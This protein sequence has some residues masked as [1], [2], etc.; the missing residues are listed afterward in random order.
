VGGMRAVL[1]QWAGGGLPLPQAKAPSTVARL[2][3][4]FG[5]EPCQWGSGYFA[6]R[7]GSRKLAVA[8]QGVHTTSKNPPPISGMQAYISYLAGSIFSEVNFAL[9]GSFQ[10]EVAELVVP[11]RG[12]D[13]SSF[14]PGDDWPTK[15]MVR[16]GLRASV[17]STTS[18]NCTEF[19]C[20]RTRQSSALSFLP[21]SLIR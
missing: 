13:S 4:L 1:G 20:A 19:I 3:I 17:F 10:R 7:G 5:P 15:P 8:L 21:K 12:P 11:Q 9:L 6:L 16:F 18:S 2:E 14:A